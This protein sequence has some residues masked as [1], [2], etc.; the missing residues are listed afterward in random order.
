MTQTY[1]IDIN[2]FAGFE[3]LSVNIKPSRILVF[4]KKAQD[5]DLRLFMGAAFYTD[6]IQYFS[7]DPTTGALVISPDIPQPYEDLWQGLTYT[8]KAGHNVGYA[9]IV[10]ALIYWTFARYI[11]ADSVHYTATGPV[12][13]RHDVG[14]AVD[15]KDIAKLVS[16]QRSVANAHA[17]DIEMYLY[18]NR[19]DFPLWRW[20]EKNKSSRQAGPRIRG[21]DKTDF[22]IPGYGN[23]DFPY[24]INNGFY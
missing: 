4:V 16:Q 13:K 20:N 17:N 14:D 12:I 21:V 24:G 1:L 15:P 10:P 23:R 5:L 9:G 2:T 22:N 3:D 8:D 11:E 18:N 19:T 7:N 6:F